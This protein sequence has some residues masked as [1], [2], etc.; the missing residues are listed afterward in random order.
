V[1]PTA[2]LQSLSLDQLANISYE[3]AASIQSPNVEVLTHDQIAALNKILSVQGDDFNIPPVSSTVL[4][5]PSPDQVLE[6]R[7][8]DNGTSV[9]DPSGRTQDQTTGQD[10]PDETLVILV[11]GPDDPSLGGTNVLT[12]ETTRSVN[13]SDPHAAHA[14][15]T[16]TTTSTTTTTPPPTTTEPPKMDEP[17]KETSGTTSSTHSNNLIYLVGISLTLYLNQL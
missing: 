14:E 2:S 6:T 13:G 7:A 15:T 12:D 8:V 17:A 5:V 1:I 11:P 16:T 10:Q 9:S 4:D 3:A